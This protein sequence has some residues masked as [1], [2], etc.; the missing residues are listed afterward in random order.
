MSAS[1][2]IEVQV[3]QPLLKA[4]G[5]AAAE[6]GAPV[7]FRL[8][9]DLPGLPSQERGEAFVDGLAK[10]DP[11]LAARLG[12]LLPELLRH[13]EDLFEWLSRGADHARRF[14]EDPV[15]ALAEAVPDFSAELMADLRTVAQDLS[16]SSQGGAR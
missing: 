1:R 9:G 6:P 16:T 10:T 2:W 14:V 7:A 13:E 15:G 11:A 3:D 5:G 4:E 8:Y 12:R